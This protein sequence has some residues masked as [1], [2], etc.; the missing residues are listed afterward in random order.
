MN[1]L[2]VGEMHQLEDFAETAVIHQLPPFRSSRVST[3]TTPS[4][5]HRGFSVFLA[6]S[7]AINW[8]E[9]STGTGMA[10]I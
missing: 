7:L 6:C 3:G 8:R 9:P 10:C 2:F 5:R 1:E 4:I